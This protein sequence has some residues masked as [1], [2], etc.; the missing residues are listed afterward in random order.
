M[1]ACLA[2]LLTQEP[3]IPPPEE[4]PSIS[5]TPLI[6]VAVAVIAAGILAWR[7]KAVP[8]FI[9]ILCSTIGGFL[10]GMTITETGYVNVGMGMVAAITGLLIATAA[11]TFARIILKNKKRP[12]A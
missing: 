12:P 9:V 6:Y 5:P 3:P 10:I 11:V 8:E 2:A 1:L 7:Y 4:T